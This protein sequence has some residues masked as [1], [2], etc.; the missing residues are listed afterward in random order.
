MWKTING[1]GKEVVWYSDEEYQTIKKLNEANKG[2]LTATAKQNY[3]LLQE[4]DKLKT[5]NEELKESINNLVCSTN[6][7]KYQEANKLKQTLEEVIELAEHWRDEWIND[8]DEK[9]GFEEILQI[10]KGKNNDIEIGV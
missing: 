10:I 4:Y 5:E 2:L 9:Q 6:C 3:Q 1:L 8:M 7:Y